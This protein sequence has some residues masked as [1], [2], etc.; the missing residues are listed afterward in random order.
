MFAVTGALVIFVAGNDPIFPEPL[1]GRPMEV[2]SLIQVNEVPVTGPPNET[3]PA[4]APL[5]E[6]TL[7][8]ALTVAVG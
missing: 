3:G 1:A 6:V 4:E 2:L 5:H 8:I 7:D